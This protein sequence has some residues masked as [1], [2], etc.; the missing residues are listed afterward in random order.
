MDTRKPW[1]RHFVVG[2]PAVYVGLAVIW[3]LFAVTPW[4]DPAFVGGPD[5]AVSLSV[6]GGVA[7]LA[8]GSCAIVTLV[9]RRRGVLPTSPAPQAQESDPR[10]RNMS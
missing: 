3:T 4:I 9:M 6:I 2:T 7:A 10:L 8:S 1:W 5:R